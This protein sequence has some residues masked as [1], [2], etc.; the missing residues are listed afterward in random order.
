MLEILNEKLV[1]RVGSDWADSHGGAAQISTAI[2][3]AVDSFNTHVFA[4]IIIYDVS[5]CMRMNAH[6]CVA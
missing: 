6:S 1:C 2:G 4:N 5:E 3:L